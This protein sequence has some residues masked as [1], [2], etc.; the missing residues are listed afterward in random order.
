MITSQLQT[1]ETSTMPNTRLP[2][3]G[4][5][6]RHD[7][8]TSASSHPELLIGEIVLRPRMRILLSAKEREVLS[9]WRRRVLAVYALLAAAIAGYL[10]LTPGT[11]TIAQGVSK[12]EQARAE[13]CVQHTGTLS[14]AADRQMP[15]QV[16]NQD[17]RALPSCASIERPANGRGAS[18]RQPQAD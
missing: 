17:T 15:R 12:D 3:S 2:D 18:T 10:A 5:A 14:D 1:R 13:T 9:T 4:P 8:I 11:R 7:S 6:R 16:A